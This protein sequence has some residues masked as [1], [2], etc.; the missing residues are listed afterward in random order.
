MGA[1][2][3]GPASAIKLAGIL[4]AK[5]D[6]TVDAQIV[7]AILTQMVRGGEVVAQEGDTYALNPRHKA[8]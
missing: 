8:A 7:G 4:R 2:K 5:G 6:T 3:V 1:L